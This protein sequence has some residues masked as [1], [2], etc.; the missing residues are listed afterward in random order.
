MDQNRLLT[1]DE[2]SL[3]QVAGGTGCLPNPCE[4]VEGVLGA[5]GEVVGGIIDAKKQLLECGVQ[6]VQ[7]LLCP[8]K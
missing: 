2:G 5:A 7:S 4:V 1:I 3:D 6:T 8:P